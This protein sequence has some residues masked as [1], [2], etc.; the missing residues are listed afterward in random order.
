[1]MPQRASAAP[2][3]ALVVRQLLQAGAVGS[4]V[5][6]GLMANDW[7]ASLALI[8]LYAGWKLLKENGPPVVAASFTAQWI[9]VNGALIYFAL[10]GRAVYQL[11]TSDYRPMVL[12]GMAAITALFAGFY[13]GARF[14][15]K[16]STT[17]YIG[18][19]LPFS[20]YQIAL[21]YGVALATS[22]ALQQFAWSA[23]GLTQFLLVFN[24]VRYV[25]LFFLITRLA[26]PTPRF[27][28]IGA[29]LALEVALGFTG[30]FADFREPLLVAGLAI[31]GSMDRRK[32]S[33]WVTICSIV[34]LTLASA[35]V[36]TAI[37]PIVRKS[38]ESNASTIGK[39]NFAMSAAASTVSPGESFMVSHADTL[40]SRLWSIYYP[41]LALK[42]VPM[43][44]PYE[45]GAILMS[46]VDN[47]LTPRLLNPDKPALPSP[48][49]EVR[50]YAG[51]WVRGRESNTSIAFGYVGES[52]VD[53]G[54][55]W[56]F[57]P[58][59]AYGLLIGVAYRLLI[60]RI[61]YAELR[62]GL[63]IVVVWSMLGSYE[64]SWVMMIGPAITILVAL[65]G[66]ALIL[67]R[68]LW[69]S[70]ARKMNGQP[71]P[72]ALRIPA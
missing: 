3:T 54:L 4:I 13:F 66:G 7:V 33:T 32:V 45:N 18:T 72:V 70:A 46:A 26:R 35:L 34:F 51:V 16:G 41:A 38:Y 8:F 64:T 1:M 39:L 36:W 71:S 24:R 5:V 49:D 58:I 15:G 67:D 53:F 20:T 9:Q 11:R 52:Y 57:A 25:L 29:V 59:F 23:V 10:T 31:F 40:V 19:L 28:A 65:G 63:T 43:I 62:V 37:K 69:F 68:Y 42:R 50:K 61:R 30:F 12:I 44:V 22:S 60:A 27:A 55:P 6:V 56:M 2:Q 48:S 17:R 14:R 21:G 47:V